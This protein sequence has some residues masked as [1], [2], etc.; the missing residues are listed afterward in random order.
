MAVLRAGC[1]LRL[2]GG[3]HAGQH[4]LP[5]TAWSRPGQ[6]TEPASCSC[7][8]VSSRPAL[9]IKALIALLHSIDAGE[10]ALRKGA[11]ARTPCPC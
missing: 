1:S 10:L 11:R 7:P 4:L 2:A 5:A 9:H 6:R 8:V 3:S